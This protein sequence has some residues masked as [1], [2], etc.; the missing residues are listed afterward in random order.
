[1]AHNSTANGVSLTTPLESP[2][3]LSKRFSLPALTR[4]NSLYP[5]RPL[6]PQLKPA[7]CVTGRFKNKGG[8][9]LLAMAATR[10]ARMVD[11]LP[12]H[13]PRPQKRARIAG[14]GLVWFWPEHL[15]RVPVSSIGATAPHLRRLHVGPFRP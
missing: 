4:E 9:C 14:W 5:G 1:M 11:I 13:P 2:S 7:A 6:P 12:G 3:V 8:H 10:N 15:R